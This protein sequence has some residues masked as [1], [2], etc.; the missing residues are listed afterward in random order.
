MKNDLGL[1]KKTKQV[2]VLKKAVSELQ[3]RNVN[4]TYPATN[5]Q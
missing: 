1:S 5:T 2:D 4:N 3:V